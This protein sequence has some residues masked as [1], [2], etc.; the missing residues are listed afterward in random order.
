M[1]L[2]GDWDP[3]VIDSLTTSKSINNELGW[4]P[5]PTVPGGAGNATTVLGGGDGFSCS[6][7]STSACPKFLEYIDSTAVQKQIAGAAVGL[8][9]NAAA[10]TA[11]SVAAEKGVLNY[12][13]NVSLSAD[14]LRRRL[15]R[16]RWQRY[17]QRHRQLLRRS[18]ELPVNHPGRGSGSQGAIAKPARMQH[19]E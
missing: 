13:K 7:Q 5:F 8:P 16:E 15:P 3:G 19:G 2:Q 6:T 10:S 1:E 17:R 14:L 4:F 11:L 9:V 18:R 12:Y